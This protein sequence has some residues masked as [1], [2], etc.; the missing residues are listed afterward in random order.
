MLKM[1]GVLPGHDAS[2][3]LPH[4]HHT[5]QH[6]TAGDSSKSQGYDILHSQENHLPPI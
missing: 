4:L 5:A 3:Q 1:Y 6:R 2:T